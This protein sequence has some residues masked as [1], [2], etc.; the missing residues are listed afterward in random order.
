MRDEEGPHINHMTDLRA[1]VML[2]NDGRRVAAD[3]HWR[4]GGEYDDAEIYWT[5]FLSCNYSLGLMA[6]SSGDDRQ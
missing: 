4:I 3:E 2:F 1:T 5:G 6:G